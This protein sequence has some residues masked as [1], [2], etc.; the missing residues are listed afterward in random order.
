MSLL[1][2]EALERN[3]HRDVQG[4]ACYYLATRLLGEPKFDRA[5]VLS[6]L[7]RC[8]GEFKD[9]QLNYEYENQEFEY[10]LADLAKPMIFATGASQR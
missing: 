4:A 9:V 10:S 7:R 5:E 8:T 1:L 2:R 3:P 6:L